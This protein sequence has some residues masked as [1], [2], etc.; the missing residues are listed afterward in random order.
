MRLVA[1]TDKELIQ[2][3]DDA[4]DY[5]AKLSILLAILILVIYGCVKRLIWR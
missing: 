1:M 5:I 3:L 2:K 4:P